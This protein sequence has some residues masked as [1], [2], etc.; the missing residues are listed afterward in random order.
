MVKLIQDRI[1]ILISNG[2]LRLIAEVIRIQV[3][4][5]NVVWFINAFRNLL[6]WRN[7][8]SYIKCGFIGLIDDELALN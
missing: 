1:T 7:Q 4:W 3:S 5:F 8:I 6:P 2:R